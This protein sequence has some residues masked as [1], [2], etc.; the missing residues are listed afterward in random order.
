MPV[1]SAPIITNQGITLIAKTHLGANYIEFTRMAAG[2]GTLENPTPQYIKPMTALISEKISFSIT[3]KTLIDETTVR[4]KSVM[5]NQTLASAFLVYEIGLFAMDPDVGEILY[6]YVYISEPDFMQQHSDQSI[7]RILIDFYI[8]VSDAE[9]VIVRIQTGIYALATDMQELLD[10][11]RHLPLIEFS[12]RTV[13][14]LYVKQ[15]DFVLQE[16]D[17]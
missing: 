5:T 7:S 1:F 9:R 13:P 11:I 2:D 3:S 4:I 10:T 15:H 12:N 6:A 14:A 8:A 17:Y 16:V